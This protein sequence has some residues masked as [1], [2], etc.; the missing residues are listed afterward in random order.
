MKYEVDF[1]KEYIRRVSRI[2]LMVA[3]LLGLIV[4]GSV[5]SP[6]G[7]QGRPG[8]LSPRLAEIT[9]YQ[10]AIQRWAGDLQDIQTG[11]GGLL[12]N[13]SGDLLAQDGKGNLLYGRLLSLQAEVDSTRVPPTLETLH[14]A[15]QNTVAATLEVALRVAAWISEPTPENSASAEGALNTAREMLGQINQNPW[16]VEP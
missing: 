4:L 3:A 16:V 6:V 14:A 7:E 1:P 2:V 8:F 15:M 5:V 10:R 11:L 9:T 13:P 12:S